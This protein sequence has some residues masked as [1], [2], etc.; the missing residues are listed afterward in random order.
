MPNFSFSLK[1]TIKSL[2]ILKIIYVRAKEQIN[3]FNDHTIQPAKSQQISWIIRGK[4][5]I[6]QALILISWREWLLFILA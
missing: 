2:N 5:R 3:L 4:N 1:N 6:F